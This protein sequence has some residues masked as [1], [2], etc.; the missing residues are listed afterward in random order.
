MKTHNL[1]DVHG[2]PIQ[3]YYYLSIY[4][5]LQLDSSRIIAS[6]IT[7]GAHYDGGSV[8]LLRNPSNLFAMCQVF[9]TCLADNAFDLVNIS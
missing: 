6:F 3:K 2:I 1:V 9:C 4:R 7:S 8:L 5:V